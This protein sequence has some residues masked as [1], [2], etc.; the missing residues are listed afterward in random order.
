MQDTHTDDLALAREIVAGS[1]DAWARLVHGYSG[2]IL[3]VARRYLYNADKD[4]RRSV[5]V[6]VLEDLYRTRLKDYDGRCSLATWIVA[7][8][9]SRSLDYLRSRYGR[10]SGPKWLNSCTSLE[11]TVYQ[12]HYLE[13]LTVLDIVRRL[14]AAHKQTTESDVADCLH[15]LAT[16]MGRR[17]RTRLAYDLH[18]R[19][20]GSPLEALS[21]ELRR[22]S[23]LAAENDNPE[24]RFFL[25]E[26]E[27]M[28]ERLRAH[29]ARLDPEE[30]E[31][32][33][34]Q[35]E[36]G[37]TA[38]ETAARMGLGGARRVYTILARALSRLRA[39]Y[40][41]ERLGRRGRLRP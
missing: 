8:T 18:A 29:V 38:R 37:L 41:D 3:S 31:V 23:E 36:E 4:E 25:T 32:V 24:V 19:N 1:T 13:G 9:R 21:E 15:G 34:F 7:I 22:V 10:R 40:D 30:R 20:G 11:H 16:R 6:H 5:Y 39:A 14:E 28:L 2:L 33:R 12:L 26:Q 17:F 27:Q 35:F